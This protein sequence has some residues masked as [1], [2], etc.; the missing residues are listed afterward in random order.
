[1]DTQLLCLQWRSAAT[2]VHDGCHWLVGVVAL[3]GWGGGERKIV[4]IFA[5]ERLWRQRIHMYPRTAYATR[6]FYSL[7]F[8]FCRVV[9]EGSMNLYT[10]IDIYI[11]NDDMMCSLKTFLL[12]LIFLFSVLCFFFC[13]M[14]CFFYFLQG[15]VQVVASPRN[16]YMY[17]EKTRTRL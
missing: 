4:S 6:R 5:W 8:L 1:M 14:F 11:C 2:R 3:G 9:G 12:W 13:R 7:Y 15:D 16:V 10:H 17:G